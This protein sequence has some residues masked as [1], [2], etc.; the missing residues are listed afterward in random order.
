MAPAASAGEGGAPQPSAADW[1]AQP[2]TS[3]RA[4]DIAQSTRRP[5]T[6]GNQVRRPGL[7]RARALAPGPALP[8]AL[9]RIPKRQAPYLPESIRPPP[10]LPSLS[11]P[12]LAP[13]RSPTLAGW[14]TRRQTSPPPPASCCRC[15]C[16]QGLAA[17]F[18]CCALG[19]AGPQAAAAAAC[20]LPARACP[21]PSQPASPGPLPLRLLQSSTIIDQQL[22]VTVA[23]ET[24]G[25][26]WNLFKNQD[27][28]VAYIGSMMGCERS[29]TLLDGGLA[30]G[31]GG[32]RT[33]TGHRLA[34]PCWRAVSAGLRWQ[35]RGQCPRMRGDTASVPEPQRARAAAPARTSAPRP[36]T[37]AALLPPCPPAC[38]RRLGRGLQPRDWRGHGC[39]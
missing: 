18:S 33:R 28:A 17:V 12:F 16:C 26:F 4:P 19:L 27:R 39:G 1:A 2:L 30:G 25:E 14:A 24:D 13:C 3:K 11:T 15:G 31:I 5:F 29:S 20:T 35:R 22:Q 10:P 8:G 7:A 37:D 36:P 34:S 38:P 21:P 9:A 23:F 32:P 6:C